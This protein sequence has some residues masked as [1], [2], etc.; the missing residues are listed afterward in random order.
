[1]RYRL[2]RFSCLYV[3]HGYYFPF[4]PTSATSAPLSRRR[5]GVRNVAVLG[6]HFLLFITATEALIPKQ[7]GLSVSP[8]TT[9]LPVLRLDKLVGRLACSVPPVL[10]LETAVQHGFVDRQEKFGVFVRATN[11]IS[12]EIP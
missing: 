9:F 3:I 8:D 6:H 7:V 1:M 2:E 4:D 12:T 11:V 10:T 5:M